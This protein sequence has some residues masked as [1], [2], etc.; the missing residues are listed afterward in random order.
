MATDPDLVA[1]MREAAQFVADDAKA[2]AGWSKTIPA[3]IRL[4]GGASQISIVAGGR[5]SR[6]AQ[7]FEGYPSGRPRSHPVF[8]GGQDRAHWHWVAMPPRPYLRP[9]I[10]ANADKLTEIIAKAVDDW[11]RKLG[12]R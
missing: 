11:T 3:S 5:A 6:Q 4:A 9:A 1:R 10:E 12:Y 7:N 8:A 2:R